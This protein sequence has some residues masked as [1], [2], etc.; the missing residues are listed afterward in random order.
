MTVKSG[1][2]QLGPISR[3]DT[4]RAV[5]VRLIELMREARSRGCD[6]VAYPELALTTFFPRWYFENQDDVDTWFE[7]EMPSLET[8]ALFDEAKKLAIGFY[9]GY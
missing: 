5:V 9:L 7:R 6:L 2:A 4:R 3:N 1:A 8:Q